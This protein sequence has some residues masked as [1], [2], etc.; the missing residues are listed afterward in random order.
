MPGVGCQVLGEW[1]RVGRVSVQQLSVQLHGVDGGIVETVSLRENYGRL[2]L[3]E[4]P[5]TRT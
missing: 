4:C 3:E 2:Q 5:R 1:S